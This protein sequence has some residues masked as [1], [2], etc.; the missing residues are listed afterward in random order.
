MKIDVA[1][2]PAEIARLK[3]AALPELCI[4]FDVLR[5]T[6]SILTGLAHGI[7][8]VIPV[9]TIEEAFSWQRQSPGIL[10]GGE[11]MGDRIPGFALGN[12]PLEYTEHSGARVVT[13]TTNGTVALRACDGASEVWVGAVLNLQ[14]LA[15]AVVLRAPSGILLV[16]AGTFDTLALEDVWA[17]GRLLSLL[18][19][20]NA[21]GE[22]TDA[23]ETSAAVARNWGESG[24]ALRASRNGRALIR[25]GRT[26]DLE[27]C[28]RESAL[29]V[30]GQMVGG[31]IRTLT[32]GGE[33]TL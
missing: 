15:D 17:A 30:V 26:A 32:L 4:V 13:T 12:S 21:T 27:W 10:L 9:E 24:A 23:A 16:C 33:G 28:A 8:E 2:H 25:A 31:R 11:R 3:G 1:L 19:D 6:S 5:A 18:R 14:A 22:W 7:R 20:R 29:K